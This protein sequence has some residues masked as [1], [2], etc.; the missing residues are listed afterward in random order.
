VHSCRARTPRPTG[1]PVSDE[2]SRSPV[3]AAPTR[4]PGSPTTP[5]P[6][7]P[8]TD[9]HGLLEGIRRRSY[10]AARWFQIVCGVSA[11]SVV[12][13]FF[14][15][16]IKLHLGVATRSPSLKKDAACS[17]CGALLSLGVCIGTAVASSMWYFD[18]LV[19]L[20]V[21]LA[22]LAHGAYTLYKN[23]KEGNHWWK[24]RFWLVPPVSKEGR[25]N[26]G[27]A[28]NAMTGTTEVA[29]AVILDPTAV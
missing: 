15:G 18:A 2:P 4:D 12:L 21:S 1:R 20:L 26:M 7:D 24:S 29:P 16:A 23:K 17:L 13:F 3:T 6:T 9:L 22:L 10:C 14:L 25:D 27:R 5:R 19:A 11:P 28:L 8:P